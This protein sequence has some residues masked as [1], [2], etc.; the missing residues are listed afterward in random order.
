MKIVDWSALTVNGLGQ[1]ATLDDIDT[2]QVGHYTEHTLE[3]IE[4]RFIDLESLASS[5]WVIDNHA[6]ASADL[7]IATG[8][9]GTFD[10]VNTSGIWLLA[11][12]CSQCYNPAPV[13]LTV[14]EPSPH[15]TVER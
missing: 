9:Q 7:T 8:P 3:Q 2:V 13:F 15:P 11:L 12:R 14:L 5:L 6:G 1:A 10:G 4:A